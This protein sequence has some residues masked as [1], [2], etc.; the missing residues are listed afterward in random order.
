MPLS[1]TLI[2]CKATPAARPRFAC[3][4]RLGRRHRSADNVTFD[5]HIDAMLDGRRVARG[6]FSSA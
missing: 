2:G 3:P 1:P 5:D 4:G 6:G